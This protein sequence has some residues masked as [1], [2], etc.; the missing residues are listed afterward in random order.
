MENG[1][2]SKWKNSLDHFE[3]DGSELTATSSMPLIPPQ[4][5]TPREPMEFLSRS[6]S[7]SA[8]EISKAL[9]QKQ[10]QFHVDHITN[11]SP[12]PETFVSP[13]LSGKVINSINARKTG[14]IGKWF[15]HQKESSTALKKKDKARIENARVHSAV[16]VA[17]LAAALAAVALA[18]NTDGLGSKMSTA[19]A[20][21]TELLA[22]HCV[23]MAESAGA[24]HDSLASV[25]SS[26]VDIQSA[27][28]LMTLT[29]AAATALRAEAALKARMPKEAR[30]NAAISP[31]ERVTT[32]TNWST[33]SHGEKE[34]P[35]SPCV[36]DLLQYTQKGELSRK[37]ASIYINKKSQVIMKLKS[38]HVGGAFSKNNKCIIY[39]VCD[40]TAA[41][42]YKKERENSDELYFGLKTAKGFLEF[43][44]KSKIHKQKWVDGIKNLL[45]QTSSIKATK[46]SLE[47]LIIKNSIQQ[48]VIM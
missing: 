34:E 23:D 39:G 30:R 43:K 33:A 13:Q 4:P 11:P 28:D 16:C 22:S 37:R 7:L 42:P 38:K 10:K 6:W 21:A 40:E 41:W 19:M 1:L 5:Q 36:G 15:H 12:I 32:E 44:C 17:G 46:A 2:Y 8:T 45:S 26:A 48:K 47:S 3:E 18:G 9:A 29:A 31:Y 35:V 14:S 27:G 25:V 24:N 20:S